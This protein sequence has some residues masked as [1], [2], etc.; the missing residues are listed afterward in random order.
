MS[1]GHLWENS[2]DRHDDKREATTNT[3]ESEGEGEVEMLR[4]TSNCAVVKKRAGENVK[5]GFVSAQRR[6]NV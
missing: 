4:N 3:N 2:E 6:S 1:K 5:F